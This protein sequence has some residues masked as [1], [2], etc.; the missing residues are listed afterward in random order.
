M[1][2][3]P[4]IGISVFRRCGICGGRFEQSTMFQSKSSPNGWVCRDCRMKVAPKPIPKP[5]P[6]LVKI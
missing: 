3:T 4:E 2:K 6:R 5:S 1:K